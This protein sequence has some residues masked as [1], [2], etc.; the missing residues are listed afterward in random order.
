MVS[1]GMWLEL[2]SFFFFFFEGEKESNELKVGLYINIYHSLFPCHVCSFIST[3]WQ[4]RLSTGCIWRNIHDG[5][6]I[7]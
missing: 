4:T 7:L 3:P 6:I 1:R 5:N 2:Q